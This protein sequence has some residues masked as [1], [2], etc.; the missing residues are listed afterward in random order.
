M[1]VLC[2]TQDTE[3]HF[4]PLPGANVSAAHESVTPTQTAHLPQLAHLHLSEACA[5]TGSVL[6][7][8]QL[9]CA[10]MLPLLGPREGG[11]LQEHALVQPD[12]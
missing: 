6:C 11:L 8:V 7:N 10:H 9:R 5:R 1:N 12:T 3:T 2:S 4:L